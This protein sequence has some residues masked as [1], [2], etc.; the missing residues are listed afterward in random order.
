MNI[1]KR[2]PNLV[3]LLTDSMTFP[4]EVWLVMHE[5]VRAT[6]RIRR[7]FDHLAEGLTRFVNG[8]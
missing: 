6:K 2:D 1:A 3:R 5:D 4:L 7:V 8:R